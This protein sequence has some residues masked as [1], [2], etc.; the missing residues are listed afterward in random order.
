MSPL[1]QPKGLIFD[2]EVVPPKN[3]QPARIM[4]VGALRPDLGAELELKVSGDPSPALQQLDALSDGASFVLGHNVIDH[5]LPILRE[6]FP[7]M[8]LHALPVIDTLRLSPL[9]FPQNPYHRLIKDYKLI[10]DSLNS[11]LSDCRSTLVL[12]LDQ[13]QAFTQLNETNQTEL[14]CYQALLAPSMRGDLGAFFASLTGQSP[15]SVPELRA[16]FPQLLQETDPALQRDLKVCR[17]RLEQL[18]EEDLQREDL[19]WPLAYALAWLRVS[20]GNS[21]LA[22]WVRHQ[23]PEVGRLISELRDMPCEREDCQYCQTTH[24]PRHELKRYFGFPDFRYEG[25]GESLQ[26]DIVLAGMRGQHVLAILATGG[27]KSLCYQL[28]ALNRFHRNGSLTVIVSPL[29]SLMKDQVDGLLERNVQCAAALNGLLTMPERAEVLEKIQMGDVGILLVS[30]EQ[31]RNKAFR[32]AIRQRQVGAWIFDEAH[33]LSKW[34]SDFRPD[35]LYV[36][37]FIREYTGDQPLAQ[38]GC[39][40]ATAKPDVLADIQSHFRESLGIEFKV[41]PGG[42]ERT[43][44][45]FDVL[46]CTKAEK[47]SRTDGLLR[48]HLDAQEGGAV[49]F[50]S[51]RK[52]AEELSDFLIGQGWP[53]KHFHAGLEPNTKTD[54][55][56]DFKAGQL[57]IIVATNAFGMGVD[58]ADIRLVVHA[59]IPGSLENYLQEAGRAGRD[60]GDARCVLLYDPQDIETQFGMSERSKLSIRDI[61]QILRKLRNES[62]RRKGGKLVITAGEILLDDDVETSFS[63][64]ERDAETKVV[65]A[66]AWLERGD[67][68]KREENHT[69]IFPA[70]LDVSEEEAEKRLL[71]AELPQR[72]LEE[73]KAILRFLYGADVDERVNTDQLMQLTSLESEEVASALKQLEEMGLLVNDSQITLYVRHGVTG[74]SSQR[75]SSSLELERALLQ[76]LPE[77]APDAEHGDWQDLNLPALTAELK[78]ATGLDELLPLHVLRLLRSLAQ[79]HDADDQQR[80]SLELRQLNRDYLKLRIKGGHSW[81]KIVGFGDVRRALASKFLELLVGKLPAGLRGA[82]LLVETSFGE[83]L[84]VIEGDLELPHLIPPNRRRK[85]IEHVLLYLHR[86]DILTLNHGMTVMR[87]AMTIEVKKEDKRKTFLKE[88]YLRL[89]EH[90]REKRIQVHVMREYAEV[91]L[92]EMAEALRLVLDY[93]TDSKQAFIKRHFNGRED[94]LKLATSEESWKSIIESLSTTQKL[95]VADDDD[96]NR[97]VLAGPGSGKTRVIVHRIAYLLRVRRV[98]ATSI[99]ALTFNRHAANEIR[100]RLLALVGADA[101]GVSVLTYHSMAMRLTGT[102]FERGATVDERALKQVLSDAVELLEGKRNIEGEDDLREQ[103][104]RGYRYILVDEYQDIDDLQY[105]LVSALAGRHAEEDGR[106]CIMAVG[107]DDQNIYAW[108]DTNN[109]YI[110]RFREDYE[111]STSFLVDNYRSSLRIIEAA[112]Q[113]IGQNLARLK[114]ANPIRIDRARQELPAGGLWEERDEQ[115]KGQVMR[116]LIDPSDREQGNL[117]AQAA[118]VELGRLLALEQGSWN[119]CAV[120]ARTHRYLWPIQAWCEQHDIPYF[121]AADK[122]TALP[123]TRQ[124][125]FVAAIDYMREIKGALCAADAWQRLSGSNQLVEAEWKSFFQTAFEQ[126]RG[127]LGDCQLGSGALIDW[128]Y[129]YARELRQQSKDGLYLG[130]VHSAK[131]LEFRHVVLLDGGWSTQVDTLADER[132][133]YYVGVTRAEQTLT[134]CEFADGNPFSRSLMRDVQQHEFQ[135]QPLPGLEVRFQQLTLKEIDIGFAGRQSPHAQIHKA[136]EALREGDPLTLKEEAGRYQLL[137]RQGNVVGRTAK[138]FQPQIGFDQCEVAAVM[139]RFTEDSEEQYRDLNKCERWEVV[140]PRGRG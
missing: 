127:E 36:S 111:A 83:L 5:D 26:H 139:V 10:R 1:P 84:Q 7:G 82:D 44:L 4:M 43:N 39:F 78:S 71:K 76:C 41:F 21:V 11:P 47:W 112:N 25:P 64:D 54:I 92:K 81:A 77:Q 140:V 75:L 53:C 132:R 99:V 138:S 9:A 121:L 100:K 124:R 68:L 48:E 119:G 61:Q 80:S 98:P 28:P 107:D 52:S 13:R 91:A 38:I 3:N 137:D 16:R 134:L 72:R 93:F 66:V 22:P 109:R 135:G 34:G 110:E 133:L 35:Y 130:T 114:E 123:I 69:Q 115:R 51:S 97:L 32:R 31:F 129:D 101:Y 102:R 85:V 120:L 56:D 23:F 17:A 117:Q 30:P 18:L 24:D 45:H 131:G 59:D 15:V 104:L 73:F 65:T 49:V 70:R 136:I 40:T 96:I 87:R 103:L 60:Q 126:M 67:Y 89:D 90:Y 63:A 88:D 12:F 42:H 94:V 106:L 116:L 113:L 20:G 62:N 79:D 29:Q 27:G 14:L 37:R 118:M 122:E 105:R 86:Q 46:P 55:Q 19:H 108:R 57:R 128:L 74:A 50:V 6:H 95:I 33:C 125:S 58:K 8:A 2:L